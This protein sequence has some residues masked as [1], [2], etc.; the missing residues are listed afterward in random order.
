MNQID[1]IKYFWYNFPE[2]YD[3]IYIIP[4]ADTHVGNPLFD[5]AKLRGYLKWVSERENAFLIFNGD[6][7]DCGLPGSV[8][9]DW[10]DQKPLKPHDQIKELARIVE[11]YDL[12]DKILAV[13][14]GSNHP[15][16][17]RRLTGHDYDLEFAETLGIEDR[18]GKYGV[19]LSIRFGSQRIGSNRAKP[20]N[21]VR[22]I[23]YTTHGWAGGRKAGASI[24]AAR[25]L[26]SIMLAD[27]YI[28]SHRHLDSVTKDEFLIFDHR[29]AKVN[30]VKRMYVTSGSFLK[31]GGYAQAKG[32]QPSGTG[33]PR[34]R[35]SGEK[36]DIHVTI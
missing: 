31:W 27:C 33:T 2:E 22:Y 35:F 5:E 24:N 26:G 32:L 36:K 29:R 12:T 4:I 25:E 3:H 13:V 28:V 21:R 19:A 7:C 16:R 9:I 23:V 10:W 30:I 11:E 1:H 20:G 6:L 17:A 14:G 34:I 18:Y 15:G 8:D